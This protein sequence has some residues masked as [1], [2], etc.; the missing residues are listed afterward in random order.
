[1]TPR[2]RAPCLQQSPA[3]DRLQRD[4][5]MLR[6]IH[7]AIGKSPL[8]RGQDQIVQLGLIIIHVSLVGSPLRPFL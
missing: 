1:M 5:Q 4:K 7:A 2:G 3:T 8:E 6:D